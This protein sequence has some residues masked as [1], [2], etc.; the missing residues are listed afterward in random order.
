MKS[1]AR[2]CIKGINGTAYIGQGDSGRIRATQATARHP[3]EHPIYIGG[4]SQTALDRIR[5]PILR[6]PY[7]QKKIP[8]RVKRYGTPVW[9]PERGSNPYARLKAADFKSATST[10][11]VI[12]GPCKPTKKE[13][14]SRLPSSFENSGA[15]DESRTRDLNLGKVALYQLSYSRVREDRL[16]HKTRILSRTNFPKPGPT[17]DGS[18]FSAENS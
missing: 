8:Y 2:Q 18:H 11:S 9:S 10:N 17:H 1:R 6:N 14:S 3:I 4:F 13:G 7:G 15:G 12:R 16:W 5:A